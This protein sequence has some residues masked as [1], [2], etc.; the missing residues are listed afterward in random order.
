MESERV[1]YT[2]NERK[3][4]KNI[5]ETVFGKIMEKQ[6]KKQISEEYKKVVEIVLKEVEK[7]QNN[8]PEKYKNIVIKEK[9]SEEIQ[10]AVDIFFMSMKI[11]QDEEILSALDRLDSS[12]TKEYFSHIKNLPLN[13]KTL[14]SKITK[15]NPVMGEDGY[16]AN[17]N[18]LEG[19]LQFVCFF[20]GHTFDLQ[21]MKLAKLYKM[22]HLIY[23]DPNDD[24]TKDVY[25]KSPKNIYDSIFQGKFI[26]LED[27]QHPEQQLKM[28]VP[29][30]PYIQA[31]ILRNEWS[32]RGYF[33]ESSAR[34]HVEAFLFTC[35]ECM[36]L[37]ADKIKDKYEK[38]CFKEL[39][40]DYISNTIKE[41]ESNP[42]HLVDGK[43][44]NE[45]YYLPFNCDFGAPKGAETYRSLTKN[46]IPGA[47]KTLYKA[48]NLENN[49]KKI[50]SIN[51]EEINKLIDDDSKYAYEIYSLKNSNNFNNS[52]QLSNIQNN[53]KIR[54]DNKLH[55]NIIKV[56]G[57]AGMG[58][59]TFL[60]HIAY[61]ELK[62]LVIF[63]TNG[64]L[65]I[66][67]LEQ[68]DFII[69]VIIRL[70]NINE[71]NCK[72]SMEKIIKDII[73]P[74]LPQ[75][76]INNLLEQG[77]IN[78]YIDG[79][80]EINLKGEN[81]QSFIGIINDFV[82]NVKYKNN[83]IIVTD[84]D[85]NANSI[86]E[87]YPQIHMSG[88]HRENIIEF[89]ERN[90]TIKDGETK[91]S[92]A[93]KIF[94]EFFQK[95]I[96]EKY[97][98]A[99]TKPLFLR[100]LIIIAE[101]NRNIPQKYDDVIKE[102]IISLIERE[103]NE[104]KNEDA[105]NIDLLLTEMVKKYGKKDGRQVKDF[106]VSFD[107]VKNYLDLEIVAKGGLYNDYGELIKSEKV[108]KLSIGLGLLEKIGENIKFVDEVYFDYYYKLAF[109]KEENNGED[110]FS[111]FLID[112]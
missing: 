105:Q 95:D 77:L 84:R 46:G 9:S 57:Y 21:N 25:K 91:K 78:V 67:S 22:L 85:S 17:A 32:H 13:F 65:I 31:Y 45:Q 20:K 28:Y 99:L 107:E 61:K 89:I 102:F 41:Y 2:D 43:F 87:S 66:K 75:I 104:K 82:T 44:N 27:P 37:V 81:L 55:F 47:Q 39:F 72:D 50:K 19:C 112:G 24:E 56:I 83:K 35:V 33:Q 71:N 62:Q 108:L 68:K 8:I 42:N 53:L 7:N 86:L 51:F 36:N 10:E 48:L 88:V 79:L 97:K 64:E 14:M 6:E 26:P 70:S 5:I 15:G 101:S 38:I 73:D 93:Q 52:N 69:P 96:S 60:E 3:K 103:I 12:D 23:G 109:P 29:L 11:L 90:S 30:M 40:K 16:I 92:F 76:F 34:E 111:N 49:P 58:K 106:S 1:E 4:L 54:F 74:K 94:E 110:I 59:T 98:S 80:N 18:F 63:S 100:K